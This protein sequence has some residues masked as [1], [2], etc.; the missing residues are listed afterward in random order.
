[1]RHTL[2]LAEP[3]CRAAPASRALRW[4]PGV[5]S[6][7]LRVQGVMGFLKILAR[8]RYDLRKGNV[9]GPSEEQDRRFAKGLRHSFG[10]AW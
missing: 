4:W 2:S 10:R 3:R 5:A 1:M 9:R 8:L 6:E 7:G